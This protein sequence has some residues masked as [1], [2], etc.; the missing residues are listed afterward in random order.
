MQKDLF[1]VFAGTLAKGFAAVALVS[2]A[3]VPIVV[4]EHQR[5]GRLADS[6]ELY[7]PEDAEGFAPDGKYLA[8]FGEMDKGFRVAGPF[9]SELDAESYG[10]ETDDSIV[11]DPILDGAASFSI[12]EVQGDWAPSQ[13]I[14]NGRAAHVA[15][16]ARRGPNDNECDVER[17]LAELARESGADMKAW[18]EGWF[19]RSD[20]WRDEIGHDA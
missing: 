13:S 14:L 12:L 10:E 18:H 15:W 9:A 5:V 8:V 20:E 4:Q 19:E 2:E 16:E 3:A 17:E 1:V 6:V 11:G 7:M